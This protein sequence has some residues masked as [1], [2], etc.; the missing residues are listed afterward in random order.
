MYVH[1]AH[2]LHG[3]IA[4]AAVTHIAMRVVGVFHGREVAILSNARVRSY[5]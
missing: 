2:G 4:V 1:T 5:M 3:H